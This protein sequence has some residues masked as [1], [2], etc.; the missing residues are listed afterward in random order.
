MSPDERRAYWRRL[1]AE[2]EERQR[3][4]REKRARR[5]TGF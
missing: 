5:R 2:I 4:A 1:D 3:E